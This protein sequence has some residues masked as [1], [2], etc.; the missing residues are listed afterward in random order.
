MPQGV[1]TALVLVL[2]C[3]KAY[4][5]QAV[6]PAY[7]APGDGESAD[8]RSSS[9]NPAELLRSCYNRHFDPTPASFQ[10]WL[11]GR[12]ASLFLADVWWSPQGG[13]DSTGRGRESR[14]PLVT[15]FTMASLDRLGMVEAQCRGYAGPLSAAI[16]LPL[17]VQAQ[18]EGGAAVGQWQYEE[19]TY[20][21]GYENPGPDLEAVEQGGW[22]EQEGLPA[23][24]DVAS[25][26]ARGAR[27]GG[28]G[29]ASGI[30]KDRSGGG[31]RSGGSR[32]MSLPEFRARLST[33]NRELLDST[34]RR[35]RA[36]FDSMEQAA[37]A[38][39]TAASRR[40]CALRL[41]LFAELV[42]D[43]QLAAVMPTN[44]L[45]NAARLAATTRLAAMLDADLAVS[46]RFSSLAEDSDWVARVAELADGKQP[47]ICILPA[48]EAT[49]A[50]TATNSGTTASGLDAQ[51]AELQ[52]VEATIA[53]SKPEVVGLWRAGRLQVFHED[54]CRRCHGPIN[55]KRWATAKEPYTVKWAQAFEPWGI[56]ARHR[57]PGYDERFR[58]W[59]YDKIQHVE[60]LARLTRLGFTVLPDAWLVHRPHRRTSIAT[61]SHGGSGASSSSKEKHSKPGG[62][63]QQ[64]KTSSHQA[65]TQDEVSP[66]L[67]VLLTP[68]GR[69]AT[70]YQ[71]YR[72]YVNRL[73][74]AER[75]MLGGG[76]SGH[77]SS[78]G[79][80]A[81]DKDKLNTV[82]DE[83]LQPATGQHPP[84][85]GR[86]TSG[87]RP[88]LSPQYT[89]CRD[90]L[91]WWNARSQELL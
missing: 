8:N 40:P 52:A 73:I 56:L 39:T 15:L 53:G 79:G 31:T 76:G 54:G 57:D 26:A 18:G 83:E 45:R 32:G 85:G 25:A 61:L 30:T 70:A 19:D 91:P 74:R 28:S 4:G 44:A 75:K 17:M 10:G 58:G 81:P 12:H 21:E 60:S 71:L 72:A 77:S 35:L 87:Y 2:L 24:P 34:R 59:C 88:Q 86:V 38:A 37:A 36:L 6:G 65:A 80:K 22:E 55:H 3:I 62:G 48:W 43:A 13:G 63:N 68:D 7:L 5:L 9:S 49:I 78:S 1:H 46:S 90:V 14:R 67:Q 16:H 84:V 89:L 69:N 66:L 27:G 42:S 20:V 11:S 33:P 23:G 82:K 41:L 64:Q 29:S 47:S 51:A 50:T